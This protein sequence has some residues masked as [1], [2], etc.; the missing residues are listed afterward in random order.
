MLGQ[1]AGIRDVLPT[2]NAEVIVV[3]YFILLLLTILYKCVSI[4]S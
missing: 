2:G 1:A 3:N 4:S